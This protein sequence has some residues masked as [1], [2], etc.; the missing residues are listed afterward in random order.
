MNL[1]KGVGEKIIKMHNIYP[2]ITNF[3]LAKTFKLGTL[4]VVVLSRPPKL[5]HI[6]LKHSLLFA[7]QI[8]LLISIQELCLWWS[9][10]DRRVA[11]RARC[12]CSGPDSRCWSSAGSIPTAELLQCCC[13]LPCNH[14]TWVVGRNFGLWYQAVFYALQGVQLFETMQTRLLRQNYS[15][16][17]SL[18]V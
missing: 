11:P 10:L 15:I 6:S 9:G 5:I 8:I 1:K 14:C 16:W 12:E 3:N 17:I 7:A 4:P 13:C 2:C 18:I